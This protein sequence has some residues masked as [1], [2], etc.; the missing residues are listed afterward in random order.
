MKYSQDVACGKTKQLFH[1][2]AFSFG[3]GLGVCAGHLNKSLGSSFFY[4]KVN[5]N[6]SYVPQQ[7]VCDTAF[8]ASLSSMPLASELLCVG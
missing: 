7:G 2:F 5:L 6:S 8:A 3:V 1:L 4:S